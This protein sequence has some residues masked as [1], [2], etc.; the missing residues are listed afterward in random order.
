MSNPSAISLLAVAIEGQGFVCIASTTMAGAVTI[1][2]WNRETRLRQ[3]GRVWPAPVM[4]H[5]RPA[6]GTSPSGM[7]EARVQVPRECRALRTAIRGWIEKLYPGVR[8]LPEQKGHF[9]G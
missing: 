5:I 9:H 7:V 2:G 8:W 6:P 4:V 1:A 3:E